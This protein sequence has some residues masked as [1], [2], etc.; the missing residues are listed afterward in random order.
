MASDLKIKNVTETTIVKGDSSQKEHLMFFES[1]GIGL[2][3]SI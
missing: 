1:I 2:G 3:K